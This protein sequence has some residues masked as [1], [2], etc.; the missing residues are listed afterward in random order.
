GAG[1]GKCDSGSGASCGGA[2]GRPGRGDD[3]SSGIAG[4]KSSAA[5]GAGGEAGGTS[6]NQIGWNPGARP[7]IIMSGNVGRPRSLP[8]GTGLG[9]ASGGNPPLLTRPISQR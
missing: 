1:S 9:G 4:R 7:P 8:L 3:R 5:V 2:G 6:G